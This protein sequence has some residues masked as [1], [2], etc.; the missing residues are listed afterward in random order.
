[1]QILLY[2]CSI[3]AHVFW[4]D[5][6]FHVCH[7]DQWK[8][9]LSWKCIGI[10]WVFHVYCAVWTQGYDLF[11]LKLFLLE[12][13]PVGS[14]LRTQKKCCRLLYPKMLLT[15]SYFHCSRNMHDNSDY[16]RIMQL[17]VRAVDL[18]TKNNWKTF[19]YSTNSGVRPKADWDFIPAWT[20]H[21]A[22][23]GPCNKKHYG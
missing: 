4:K 20:F 9:S 1:M 22:G 11:G 5:R 15:A 23:P 17:G 19:V 6:K 7:I 2:R 14:G 13:I 10:I 21:Y 3:R 8:T 18:I 16:N 12:I